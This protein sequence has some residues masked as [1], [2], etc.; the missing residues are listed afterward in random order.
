MDYTPCRIIGYPI[1]LHQKDMNTN[2]RKSSKV[3]KI[4]GFMGIG[5]CGLCC[6]LPMLGIGSFG[7]MA[8]RT[9][10]AG[11]ISLIAASTTLSLILYQKTKAR[12]CKIN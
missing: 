1:K 3:A 12:T 10:N 2:A 6:A 5:L 7:A 4:I 8:I 9:E 11:L